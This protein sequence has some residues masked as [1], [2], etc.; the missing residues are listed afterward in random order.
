MSHSVSLHGQRRWFSVLFV[1]NIFC[2][3]LIDYYLASFLQERSR[4]IDHRSNAP[5]IVVNC[6]TA[7]QNCTVTVKHTT[8]NMFTVSVQYT[9]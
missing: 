8:H 1:S 6:T 4:V 2:V 9:L 3:K 5:L 7:Q